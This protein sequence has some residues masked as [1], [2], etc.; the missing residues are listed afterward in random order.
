MRHLAAKYKIDPSFYAITLDFDSIPGA[1]APSG[2]R[3]VRLWD[4][5]HSPTIQEMF[6]Y[7][8]F[9]NADWNFNQCYNSHAFTDAGS[10]FRSRS[11]GIRQISWSWK[12]FSIT[13]VRFNRALQSLLFSPLSPYR[14]IFPGRIA[15]QDTSTIFVEYHS[16]STHSRSAVLEREHH[17]LYS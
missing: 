1:L 12:D 4:R 5:W 17:K 6:C 2:R 13:R 8:D 11:R 16:V 15:S 10:L 9:G 7:L 3:K 14:R